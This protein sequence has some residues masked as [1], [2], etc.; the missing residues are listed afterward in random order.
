MKKIVDKVF[1][2]CIMMVCQQ[3]HA[4]VLGS[5]QVSDTGFLQFEDTSVL[6]QEA[7]E[8]SKKEGGAKSE[9][10]ITGMP[11]GNKML[12]RWAVSSPSLWREALEKGFVLE[13][14][15][16][17]TV[18]VSQSTKDTSGMNFIWQKREHRI[19][20]FF[21]RDRTSLRKRMGQ[22]IY[23]D[24][25]FEAVTLLKSDPGI[26]DS[27]EKERKDSVENENSVFVSGGTLPV[28]Q[29]ESEIQEEK[30]NF[31]FSLLALDRSFS[32]ACAVGMGFV[33]TLE[34]KGSF[35]LYRLYIEGSLLYP[36][37]AVFFSRRGQP[38][39]IPPEH[40]LYIQRNENRVLVRWNTRP[41]EN[42]CVGYNIERSRNTIL[43]KEDFHRLN[44]VLYVSLQ[45]G[46]GQQET[47]NGFMS[48]VDSSADIHSGY[49]Y[50]V[51]GVDIFGNEFPVAH[52]KISKTHRL[53]SYCPQI[54]S[55]VQMPSA[56]QRLRLYWSFNK[57]SE[58]LVED[59]SLILCPHPDAH[60]L[61]EGKEMTRVKRFQ[62]Q[63]DIKIE[64][65][66]PSSYLYMVANTSS[67]EKK[68][69]LPFFYC[70]IDSLPPAIPEK[71]YHTIDSLGCM[72]LT[73]RPVLDKDSIGY[74]VYWK[75]GLTAEPVQLTGKRMEDTVFYDTVSLKTGHSFYYAVR[76][77]DIFGN[78][79]AF[80]E[81]MEVRNL[82]PRKP[83]APVFT[84]RCSSGKKGVWLYWNGSQASWVESHRLYVDN[85]NGWRE[86]V[87]FE[88]DPGEYFFSFDRGDTS[89]QYRFRIMAIG[90]DE[91]RDTASCPFFY[92][93]KREQ[94]KKFPS[95]WCFADRERYMIHIQW[96]DAE[97]VDVD[98]I[99]LFREEVTGEVLLLAALR[100]TDI[101]KGF[102]VDSNIKINNTYRYF[103]QVGYKDG[104]W[105]EYGRK[106]EVEY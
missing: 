51:T 16:L 101:A 62:R 42:L 46:A 83:D 7:D 40:E 19:P 2:I 48:F 87:S 53:L 23:A 95:L 13:C 8:L 86:E 60:P 36:D 100:R 94:E 63:V 98:R 71:L 54:D 31:V 39:M 59:F 65:L 97:V 11:K 43:E 80:S 75:N 74:R 35:F 93:I 4:E 32:L 85:G 73:W 84:S 105:S 28:E 55:V 18:S 102:W 37:T 69:S 58:P 20:S 34:E 89:C 99:L 49:T 76:S 57:D 25:F 14:Y 66:L 5:F 104:S 3:I 33:D 67:G 24:L 91:N 56:S 103:I 79:S 45:D 78:M 68:V 50:R 29:L 96:K 41:W 38:L 82:L 26:P 88:D 15:T 61:L 77:E 10:I 70:K 21:G 1:L 9:L 17:D 12:L 27:V 106:Y 52:G 72:V 90:P 6:R 30:M 22:D 81:W 64:S 47:G 44:D 92:S